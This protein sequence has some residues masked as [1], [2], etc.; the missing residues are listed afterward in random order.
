MTPVTIA[1]TTAPAAHG[2]LLT[3]LVGATLTGCGNDA[4]PPA[5]EAPVDPGAAVDQVAPPEQPGVDPDP[6][7]EPEPLIDTPD[8][9]LPDPPVRTPPTFPPPDLPMETAEPDEEL[10]TAEGVLGV[11]GT[12]P[13]LTAVL[14]LDDGRSLGLTGAPARELMRL[15]GARAQV[16]GRRAGTPVGPGIEVS[17]YQVLEIEGQRPYL[18][19]LQQDGDGRWML[20]RE[21][22]D[23]LPLSGLPDDRMRDGM[24]IWVIGDSD[25]TG[26]FRVDSYG[27]VSVGAS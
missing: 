15:S 26:R 5:D 8:L 10:R 23:A 17:A 22:R 18:G 3:L 7:V 4:P 16:E 24:K 14:H 27:I 13:A 20:L 25:A 11:G 19:T 9:E 6:G 12:E 21:D 2:L 1:R